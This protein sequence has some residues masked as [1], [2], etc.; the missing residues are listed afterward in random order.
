MAFLSRSWGRRILSESP[1]ALT[2]LNLT[3]TGWLASRRKATLALVYVVL[4]ASRQGCS[5][6]MNCLICMKC[7]NKAVIWQAWSHTLGLIATC[8]Y[9]QHE[10]RTTSLPSGFESATSG[11]SCESGFPVLRRDKPFDTC[12]VSN[13][14]FRQ[15]HIHT[16][17]QWGKKRVS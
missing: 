12:E 9:W 16:Y 6:F 15:Q 11:G 14:L 8:V 1:P 5:V 17:I 10:V 13:P 7:L 3:S 4:S 2:G